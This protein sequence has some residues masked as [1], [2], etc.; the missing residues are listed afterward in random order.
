MRPPLRTGLAIVLLL[1]LCPPA[2]AATCGNRIL[3]YPEEACDDGPANGTNDCCS[4]TCQIV[5]SDG[6]GI[7]DYYDH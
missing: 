3:E 5:D 1:A 4:A 7:C 6:D 2:G